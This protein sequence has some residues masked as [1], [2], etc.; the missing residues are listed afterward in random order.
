MRAVTTVASLTPESVSRFLVG[1][2]IEVLRS[3]MEDRTPPICAAG[4]LAAL[5]TVGA[6]LGL[7]AAAATI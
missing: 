4:S 6:L 1:G 2:F 3:W 5:D 7:S